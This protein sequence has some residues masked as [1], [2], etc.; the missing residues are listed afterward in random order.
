[1]KSCV[2]DLHVTPAPPTGWICKH[3]PP[4]LS[5]S[6]STKCIM[7][8]YSCTK[9]T[10][11][12]ASEILLLLWYLDC[13]LLYKVLS[14]HLQYRLCIDN[15]GL[16]LYYPHS[17]MKQHVLK[18]HTSQRAR[19]KKRK[20]AGLWGCPS[21]EIY[22]RRILKRNLYAIMHMEASFWFSMQSSMHIQTSSMRVEIQKGGIQPPDLF[23]GFLNFRN[24]NVFILKVSKWEW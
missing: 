9:L 3:P 21:T 17:T 16:H 7:G 11:L 19:H 24:L 8:L 13:F 12:G 22:I 6:F 1:M 10:V 23:R 20:E 4:T 14:V 5:R 18:S 2:R 15:G